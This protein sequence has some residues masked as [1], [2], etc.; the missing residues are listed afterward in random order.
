MDPPIVVNGKAKRVLAMT[1]W[2]EDEEKALH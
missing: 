1:F 2:I